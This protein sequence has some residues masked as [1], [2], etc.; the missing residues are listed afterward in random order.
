MKKKLFII[1]SS[2]WLLLAVFFTSWALFSVQYPFISENILPFLFP[3]SIPLAALILSILY[4]GRHKIFSIVMVVLFSLVILADI[5]FVGADLYNMAIA[6]S[7]AEDGMVHIGP[8]L[9]YAS[10]F[11]SST[12]DI[13]NYL[14]VED[15]DEWEVSEIKTYFPETIPEDSIYPEYSF[16]HDTFFFEYTELN[17]S[18]ELSEKAF[19]EEMKRI[20]ALSKKKDIVTFCKEENGIKVFSFNNEL[21]TV[22]FD[23]NS[24][25][26]NY[27]FFFND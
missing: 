25:R 16:R 1:V 2:I 23:N 6:D 14:D 24:H 17:A 18:W 7:W 27:N 26:V 3:I 5:R 9:S 13:E 8:Y 15:L 22:S 19:D 21:V 4:K 11:T 20:D 10:M 12:D